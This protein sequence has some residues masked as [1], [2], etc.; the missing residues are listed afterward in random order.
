M[1][2]PYQDSYNTSVTTLGKALEVLSWGMTQ[3]KLSQQPCVASEPM[4]L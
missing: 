2:T 4:S 1:G 3:L